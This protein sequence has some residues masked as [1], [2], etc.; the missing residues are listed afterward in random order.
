[1]KRLFSLILSAAVIAMVIVSCKDDFNEQDFLKLQSELKLK[2][3]STKRARD[4]AAA[5]S[6]SQEVVQSY[7]DAQNA[8]GALMAVTII[9]REDNTPIQGVAVSISS[10]ASKTDGRTQATVNGTTDALGTVVFETAVIANSTVTLSRSGYVT[11]S[12][13]VDFGSPEA[14][15]PVTVPS[16]TGGTKILYI[17]PQKRYENISLPLFSESATE[18]NTAVIK[19]NFTIENDMT[20]DPLV[21]DVIPTGLTISANIGS[22]MIGSGIISSACHCVGDY[23][24]SGAAGSLGVAQIQPNGDFSMRVPATA[25]GLQVELIYPR[26]AGTSRMAIRRLNGQDV[27]PQFMNVPTIW[28]PGNGTAIGSASNA[29]PQIPGAMA[30]FTAATPPPPGRGFGATFAPIARSLG[31]GTISANGNTTINFNTYN[32]VLRGRGYTSSPSVSITGG[33]GSGALA[34]ASLRGFIASAQVSNGGTGYTANT[35][36]D[37]VFTYTD[38]TGTPNEINRINVTSTP[39]GVLP[40]GTLTLPNAYGFAGGSMFATG[41][42][43]QGFGVRVSDNNNFNVA[44]ATS[45]ASITFTTETE[46]DQVVITDGGTGFLSAPTI[47]FSGGGTS[48]QA[49]ISVPAYRSQY[50]V[51]L[52]PA[53][54]TTTPYKLLPAQ[55]VF[56]FPSNAVDGLMVESP[57]IVDRLSS[58]LSAVAQNVTLLSQIVTDGTN[59][60]ALNPQHTFRT[61]QFWTNQPT[62]GVIDQTLER[63]VANVTISDAGEVTSIVDPTDDVTSI[64]D[65]YPDASLTVEG[66]GYDAL[67]VAI[68]PTITP[69]APGSGA[70]FGL[71]LSQDVSTKEVTW[72]GASLQISAGSGYLKNLNRAT[73]N[74]AYTPEA[75]PRVVTG[76]TYTININA[77]HGVRVLDVS[78][79]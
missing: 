30:V 67:S 17:S 51:T 57:A 8:A 10:G 66:N 61:D 1:M 70:S 74:I 33:S 41:Q 38:G 37:I 31:Q 16:E 68:M 71:D 54:A 42:G 63:A 18:G 21:A 29:I 20:N 79:N 75:S 65:L 36:Y 59:I 77:G 23:R 46:V 25:A 52:S 7:I 60:T 48:T 11:A 69:G 24:F 78:N 56:S 22:A 44:T 19:G 13:L 26:I 32:F 55:L 45:N 53:S 49:S 12:A 35:D 27:A 4:K 50:T 34:T 64:N 9:V 73:S 3:D 43:T 39:A 76:Q 5:Q 47:A 58:N 28:E 62:L 40:V 14:P 72:S 2:Q 15:I 6:A